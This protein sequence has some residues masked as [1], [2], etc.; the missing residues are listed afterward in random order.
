M[1]IEQKLKQGSV[2]PRRLLNPNFTHNITRHIAANPKRPKIQETL[3]RLFKKPALILAG[4]ALAITISGTAYATTTY[5]PAISAIV[6]GQQ[7]MPDGSR[8]VALTTQN[9]Q[10]EYVG[11]HFNKPAVDGKRYYAIKKDSTLTNEQIAKL[12]T[13]L[14]EMGAESDFRINV[15]NKELEKNPANVMVGGG[16]ADCIITAISSNSITLEYNAAIGGPDGITTIP[17]KETFTNFDPALLVYHKAQ[18]MQL[19]GLKVGDHISYMAR[20]QDDRFFNAPPGGYD[21]AKL[22]LV[23]IVKNTPEM[24]AAYDY[25]L[26]LSQDFKEVVP[27]SAASGFCT[28][29]QL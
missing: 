21:T 10:F 2:S 14:C 19:N 16:Y 9:C 4:L 25:S 6:S 17:I 5:W 26:H 11:F 12:A 24:S 13:G 28:S 3:M 29:D 8:I 22:T 15:I 27:C 7:S 20:A 23:A 1:T 18:P